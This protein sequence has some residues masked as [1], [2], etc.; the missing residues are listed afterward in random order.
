LFCDL[1]G[2][3]T[4]STSQSASFASVPFDITSLATWQAWKPSLLAGTVASVVILGNGTIPPADANR[5]A[6]GI[7][8]VN[9][10][11]A[12]GNPVAY[13]AACV[14]EVVDGQW[15]DWIPKVAGQRVRATAWARITHKNGTVR[16]EQLTKEM[17]AVSQNTDGI[18]TPFS[19][20]GTSITQ[21]SEP[22]PQGLSKAMWTSWQNLAI[23]GSVSNVEAVIG[24]AQNITR[25]SSLNFK[26]AAPGVNGAPDWRAVN[27]LVQQ[28]SGDIAKGISKVQFGAPL[29][30]TG[31]DLID[32][33]R[34]TRYRT[35]T[36]DINY[37]FGGALAG[38]N[39]N[40]QFGRKMHA[41]HTQHG[42]T[43]KE[44][45]VVS[46]A[47]LPV[48]GTDPVVKTDG[49]T[50]IATWTPP[51][52]PP[53]GLPAGVTAP[54]TIDPAKAAGSDGNWHTVRL[55]EEKVCVTNPDG[56]ASQRTRIFLCSE[57]FQA[58]DD[59]T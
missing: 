35:T 28:I 36:I 8:T 42:G 6:P 53:A 2:S 40:V 17:T 39:S 21:Y 27:A 24:A 56:T 15:A 54:V 34:A 22:I 19:G 51:N 13:N 47:V 50:G 30:I 32:A 38:G 26:T 58:P 23:E 41:R 12:Q 45:D 48:V 43:H 11:D 52:F 7:A 46:Q 18:N 44:V 57:P 25:S 33:L 49:T 5:P 20:G 14:N 1:T 9:E 10:L 3:A 16:Y 55:Q 37:L 59:P 31:H 4:N 29:K